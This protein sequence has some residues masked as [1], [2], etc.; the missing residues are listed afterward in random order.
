MSLNEYQIEIFWKKRVSE[1]LSGHIYN[2]NKESVK[3]EFIS[4]IIN[5]HLLSNEKVL[6][7]G[8]GNG[9]YNEIFKNYI[10]VDINEEY[11]NY[12]KKQFKNKLFSL[13]TLYQTL[14]DLTIDSFFSSECLQYNDD[15]SIDMI[16][17]SL[18]GN[19]K[20]FY[21]YETSNIENG[22]TTKRT[23]EDYYNLFSKQYKLNIIESKKHIVTGETQN[24]EF[25]LSIFKRIEQ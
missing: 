7:Y 14:Y 2:D 11:I 8:C 6:H 20:T 23:T 4:S 19:I 12:C 13:I 16:V 18:P 1:I 21:I 5:E 9:Q 3:S 10:G 24:D 22:I 25:T 15:D 17:E